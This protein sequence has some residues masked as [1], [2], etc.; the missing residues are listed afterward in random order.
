VKGS[1]FGNENLKRR[2][3]RYGF[4][5][6]LVSIAFG[7]RYL[8]RGLLGEELPFMFFIAA[9][10]LAAWYGGAATGIVALL[11]GLL[12]ADYF[13]IWSGTATISR[14]IV[15][16]HVV[17]YVF[18]ASLGITL[19][20]VMHRSRQRLQVAQ[21]QL[22]RHAA[23]LESHVAERTES[24]AATVK[25]LEDILYHIAHNLRAP[26]R[27]ME[28]Y[29]EILL[30]EH[31]GQ[32]NEQGRDYLVHISEAAARMDT[33]IADLLAYGRLTHSQ[34][35]LTSVSLSETLSR[36]VRQSS[37]QIQTSKADLSIHEIPYAV[38]A[39]AKILEQV[40]VNLLDNAIKFTAQ[41]VRPR[42]EISAER[43]NRTVRVSVKDNGIGVPLQ[44]RE[45]IFGAFERL[46]PADDGGTGI[47]LAI[48]KQGV[49][50]MGGRAGVE[51]ESGKGS[52]FWIELALAE[53][54]ALERTPGE[55]DA[56][57]AVALIV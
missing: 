3:L 19:I 37:Y 56:G 8:L 6:L 13:F 35:T 9:A 41:N 5:V 39:D 38:R 45:R 49:E 55:P 7:I 54:N 15:V 46:R 2:L 1:H 12:A 27:A 20:E 14:P 57:K 51:S 24:L 40:L 50:R 23:E 25:S 11:L 4:A 28:G 44:Y 47:G 29:S 31:A 43:R 18:T 34:V 10:L 42:I 30:S 33:L 22:H 36:A 53:P 21:Q 48:V 52:T 32:I 26:L 17:R 16:L